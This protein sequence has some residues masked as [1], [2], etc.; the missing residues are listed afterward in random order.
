MTTM[1]LNACQ[2]LTVRTASWARAEDRPSPR[3]GVRSEH[4]SQDL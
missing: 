3:Y 4:G 1:K 2:T